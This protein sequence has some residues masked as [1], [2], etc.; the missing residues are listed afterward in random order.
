MNHDAH[1]LV[2]VRH[3]TTREGIGHCGHF[4]TAC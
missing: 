1:D 4:E 3:D 2:L